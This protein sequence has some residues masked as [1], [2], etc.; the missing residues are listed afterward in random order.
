MSDPDQ[1]LLAALRNHVAFAAR[2][3]GAVDGFLLVFAV[4]PVRIRR[5]RRLVT[6]R[7]LRQALARGL[8][9]ERRRLR[10]VA[11]AEDVADA[12]E[13]EL[14]RAQNA[15]IASSG[16]LIRIAR[17]VRRCRALGARGAD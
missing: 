15:I 8:A 4:Q 13:A 14:R 10:F 17:L 1:R 6:G 5:R 3:V 2:I 11:A 12:L 9:G 7:R 16:S